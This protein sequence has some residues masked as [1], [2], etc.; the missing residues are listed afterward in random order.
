MLSQVRLDLMRYASSNPAVVGIVCFGSQARGDSAPTSDLDLVIFVEKGRVSACLTELLRVV[1]PLGNPDDVC[2]IKEG[3][4]KIVAFLSCAEAQ[5]FRLDLFV[6]AFAE[7]C[8]AQKY[9]DGSE[10][11]VE[12]L[13][14]ALWYTRPGD[15]AGVR[16]W[17]EDRILINPVMLP[18][19]S[20]AIRRLVERILESLEVASS[21]RA[22]GDKFQVLFQLHLAYTALIKLEYISH[23][24]RRFLYLPKF[25]FDS[26]PGKVRRHFED[27]LEPRG[28]LDG[29]HDQLCL[30]VQQF[31]RT[32]QRLEETA[33][34]LLAS[35]AEISVA[36]AVKL[37]QSVLESDRFHNFRAVCLGSGE[38][39]ST[40]RPKLYRSGFPH[41]LR[42]LMKIHGIRSILDLRDEREVQK[43]P[44]H[45]VPPDLIVA[46]T[47]VFQAVEDGSDGGGAT[48]YF[49]SEQGRPGLA[50][51]LRIVVVLPP[52]LLI[53]CAAGKDRTG[54]IV[55]LLMLLA[56]CAIGDIVRSYMLSRQGVRAKDVEAFIAAVCSWGGYEREQA[57]YFFLRSCGLQDSE[58]VELKNWVSG[59]GIALP[60]TYKVS[61]VCQP[62]R[63]SVACRP[64][65]DKEKSQLHSSMLLNK[66]TQIKPIAVFVTGL[67]GAGKTTS[68]Q[69]FLHQESLDPLTFVNLD[70]DLVRGYHGQ[71]VQFSN[72]MTSATK[73]VDAESTSAM[74]L[75]SFQELVAWFI[76]GT[77]CEELIYRSSGGVVQTLWDRR[78]N[79]VLP[80]VMNRHECVS[81]VRDCAK[82]GYQVHLV[83]VRTALEVATARV[84]LRNVDTGR[85]TPPEIVAAGSVG[86]A[87]TTMEIARF[88]KSMG[89]AVS[90]YDNSKD[91][92]VTSPAAVFRSAESTKELSDDELRHISAM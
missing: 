34:A 45:D 71:F 47:N 91:G 12:D 39:A 5:V 89:G 72:G 20:G 83:C 52:P 67:A 31:Q 41:P 24:G 42:D 43:K 44:H 51:A 27:D 19:G 18:L 22:Q 84:E 4:C 76:D 23:G 68:L 60:E 81:F 14:R 78:L 7:G 90:L 59:P 6:D 56:G 55:A 30:Y 9:I 85:F 92:R 8:E 1:V 17:L 69:H 46:Q 86:L 61:F 53:H 33:P 62:G 35:L 37:L 63:P 82:R 25:V 3:E 38:D 28:R 15:T 74:R 88:V 49:L 10:L 21:K 2:Y 66:L 11:R 32:M 65:S 16:A 73:A 13:S 36:H 26:L 48:R 54:V 58:Y 79:F 57:I 70:M 29:V 40:M 64:F 80:A 77:D 75:F 87:T 50:C